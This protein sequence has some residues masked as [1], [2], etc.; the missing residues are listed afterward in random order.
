[1]TIRRHHTAQRAFTLVELLV[2]IAIIG[3]LVGLLLPAVQAAREAARRMSCSNNL[4]NLG[5]ACL[6]YVDTKKHLPYSVTMWG[7]QETSNP[8]DGILGKNKGGPGYSG[9]GWIV[10]ILPQIEQQ[11][12]Y[13]RIIAAIDA[14]D[15]R[16]FEAK[17][18][19]GWG[20]G[21]VDLRDIVTR[22][23]SI[24]TCPSDPSAMPNNLLYHW[25][26]ISN[27]NVAVT[28]YKGVM[29]DNILWTGET[30]ESGERSEGSDNDLYTAKDGF[31]S[32]PDC[33]AWADKQPCNGLFWRMAYLDPIQLKQITDGQSNTLMIG[34]SVASQDYHSAAFFADG[35]WAVCSL[36]IN[37]FL[38]EGQEP[39][40]M[41][42]KW[43]FQRGFKSLHPGGAQFV[44]A[45]GSVHFVQEAINHQT[46][47]A[48]A[49]RNGEEVASLE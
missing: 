31:G 41:V 20:M 19:G 49:T 39:D 46:Y 15:G 6:N 27:L 17:T 23:L 35:D 16:N 43:Y 47:R 9:R 3:T 32:L 22:Q 36:P 34:E 1:M 21:H 42:E 44:F 28:S 37:H 30:R 12:L 45:D 10:E 7:W 2:V 26:H 38:I 40:E 13:D 4:K 18:K 24:L 14:S 11:A 25:F 5:L 29:G 48:F 8:A 33:H